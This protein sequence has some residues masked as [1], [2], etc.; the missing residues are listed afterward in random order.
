MARISESDIKDILMS[1]MD[2]QLEDDIEE[3]ADLN[4]ERIKVADA[5]QVGYMTDDETIEL[6][7]GDKTFLITINE[8]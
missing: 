2:N 7:I 4:D 6:C 5:Q 1:Y 3:Y 8:Q